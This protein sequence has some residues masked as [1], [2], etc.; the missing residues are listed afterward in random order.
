MEHLLIILFV[1]FSI[2]SA[3][4]ERRKRRLAREQAERRARERDSAEIEPEEEE[5]W[6]SFPMGDPFDQ[7]PQPSPLPGVDVEE[8]ERQAL[9]A[10]QR[11]QEMEKRAME[12][13]RLSE[14]AQPRRRA[15]E[16][17]Q[18]AMQRKEAS[19]PTAGIPLKLDPESARLAVIYAEILGRPKS[20]RREGV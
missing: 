16:A 2:V 18:E 19:L 7:V 9:A 3:L 14:E 15:R 11:T 5:D 13:E 12:M 6:P 17:V 10:E 8:L 4:L 20:E 1:L